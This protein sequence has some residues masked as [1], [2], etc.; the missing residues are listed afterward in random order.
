MSKSMSSN[1]LVLE[2]TCNTN[3]MLNNAEVPT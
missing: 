2:Q 1:I 3:K